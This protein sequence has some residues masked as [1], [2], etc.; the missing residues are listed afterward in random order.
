MFVAS[1]HMLVHSETTIDSVSNCCVFSLFVFS[2]YILH[3]VIG[4]EKKKI[5]TH[6][7]HLVLLYLIEEEGKERECVLLL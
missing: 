6:F 3:T 5:L 2:F 1:L 7:S 4:R